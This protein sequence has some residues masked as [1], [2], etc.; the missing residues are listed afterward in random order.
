M[1]KEVNSVVTDSAMRVCMNHVDH[2]GQQLLDSIYKLAQQAMRDTH[3]HKVANIMTHYCRLERMLG[4][5]TGR[6][7]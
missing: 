6:N 1:T 4:A 5:L 2:A 7:V 3:P